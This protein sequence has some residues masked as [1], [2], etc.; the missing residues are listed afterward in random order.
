MENVDNELKEQLDSL[1]QEI[2]NLKLKN[3]QKEEE[4]IQKKKS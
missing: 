3:K 2:E 1:L 4:V